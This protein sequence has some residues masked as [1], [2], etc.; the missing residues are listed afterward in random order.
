MNDQQIP[1]GYST[2]TVTWL[3]VARFD[4]PVDLNDDSLLNAIASAVTEAGG[5]ANDEIIG[6]LTGEANGSL[7]DA[8]DAARGYLTAAVKR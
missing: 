4:A 3:I 1:D 2:E 5:D 8:Y 7:D 6:N